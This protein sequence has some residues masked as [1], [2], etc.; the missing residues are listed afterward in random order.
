ML[1]LLRLK[2]IR[3]MMAKLS[4]FGLDLGLG[5]KKKRH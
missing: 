1:K 2:K 5:E 3:D 4:D